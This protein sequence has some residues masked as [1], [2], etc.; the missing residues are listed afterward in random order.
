MRNKDVFKYL[1][2]NNDYTYNLLKTAEELQELSL[3][4]TQLALKEEKVDIQE[5]IDEIGDVKIRLKVL[6]HFFYFPHQNYE[7][8]YYFYDTLELLLLKYRLFYYRYNLLKT[9]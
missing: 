1:I 9:L 7:I 5:V 8:H 4:L 6:N 2:Q 3:V